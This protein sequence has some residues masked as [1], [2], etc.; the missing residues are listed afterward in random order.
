M[1]DQEH[2]VTIT[3]LEKESEGTEVLATVAIFSEQLKEA[4]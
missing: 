4:R 1:L 3:G 2:S